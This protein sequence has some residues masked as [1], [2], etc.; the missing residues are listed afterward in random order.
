[1]GE[2][3]IKKKPSPHWV[4]RMLKLS[5]YNGQ[6]RVGI[7]EIMAITIITLCHCD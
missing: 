6:H 7:Q 4:I 1:M 3:K 5:Q 2:N